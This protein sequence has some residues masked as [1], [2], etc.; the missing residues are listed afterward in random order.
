MTSWRSAIL[1]GAACV[2]CVF[3]CEDFDAYSLPNDCDRSNTRL[4]DSGAAGHSGSSNVSDAA[5]EQRDAQG[6]VSSNAP[7]DAGDGGVPSGD[8][9]APDVSHPW[10]TP[11]L[12][13][14]GQP[15]NHA[16]IPVCFTTRPHTEWDGK[17]QCEQQHGDV[18]CN[19]APFGGI[20]RNELRQRLRNLIEDS[21]QRYGGI[22]FF[23]WADCPVDS[24]DAGTALL[25]QIIQVTFV[26]ACPEGER[27]NG[28]CTTEGYDPFPWNEVRGP[29]GKSK[30]RPTDVHI[31]WQALRDGS[32]DRA[33]IHQFGHALGF[34][35]ARESGA[36]ET[37]GRER[38][39]HDPRAPSL[40][41]FFE[42]SDSTS[43][44]VPCPSLLP[45]RDQ[46]LSAGDVLG[47]Q[48]WYGRKPHGSL[49]GDNGQ[50]VAAGGPTNPKPD[51]GDLGVG[52]FPCRATPTDIWTKD[53]ASA[54][55]Q[56]RL[57]DG[58]GCLAVNDVEPWYARN[59]HCTTDEKQ[60]F[61]MKNMEWRAMGNLC[62][63][64]Q[65]AELRTA[66]CD[67]SYARSAPAGFERAER[68]DA[69]P[70]KRSTPRNSVNP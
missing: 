33:V 15:G 27:S 31:D 65:G 48:S 25:S 9:N 16:G 70:G 2:A 63:K 38:D 11:P 46:H 32:A 29:L 39:D 60:R 24:S 18:A 30:L 44:M 59:T 66:L 5:S 7:G 12:W 6:D 21:W 51:G 20:T 58:R 53:E 68:T 19:G 67:D 35:H 10:Q 45:D 17:K 69:C 43:I 61:P 62:V 40:T 22:E 26:T 50:C 13:N 54:A 42:F 8:A 28:T 36:P 64:A 52:S 1:V 56:L 57:K 4:C 34:G 3:A 49:V 14:D 55:E 41:E 37:C 23:F 47:L